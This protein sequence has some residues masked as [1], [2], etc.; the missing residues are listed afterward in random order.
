MATIFPPYSRAHLDIV[1]WVKGGRGGGKGCGAGWGC[2]GGRETG[3]RGT[4]A[5]QFKSA[6]A[7][8]LLAS[9][10]KLLVPVLVE[11]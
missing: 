1:V 11:G 6:S 7:Y 2:R 4:L 8:K 10:M 9:E 3:G 5:S